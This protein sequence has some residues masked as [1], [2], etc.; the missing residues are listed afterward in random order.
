MPIK[1]KGGKYYLTIDLVKILPL[2]VNCIRAYIRQGRIKGQ[3]MG[4]LWYVSDKDL[5]KFLEGER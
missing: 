5:K 1:I 3:K 4:K 2:N